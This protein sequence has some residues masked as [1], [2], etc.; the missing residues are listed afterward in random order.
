MGEPMDPVG[1]QILWAVAAVVYA[2]AIV[3]LTKWAYS[4]MR[5][6]GVA[7]NVA[8]YYNRKI[9]H[10]AAGGVVALAVPF[11]F[12]SPIY[13]LAIGFALTAFTLIPHLSGRRL[14]WLQTRDNRND[15]KFTMMWGLAIFGLWL[16][17]D[18]PFLAILPPVFMAFGDGVTGVARNAL[19]KRRTKSSIGNLFMIA[20]CIP[21]GF[22]L[23]GEAVVPIPWWGVIAGAVASIIERF[24][25]GPIDDNILITLASSAVLLIGAH[26]GPLG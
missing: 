8:V 22:F 15:V 4:R 24:E 6:R 1:M 5:I 2:A 3:L 21:L 14:V 19:F 7:H 23:A 17:L 18:D 13:P 25:F 9:V 12:T 10:M 20:V 11:L 16:L 26:V